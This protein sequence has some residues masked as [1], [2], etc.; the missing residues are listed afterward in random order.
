MAAS[1][2]SQVQWRYRGEL[3]HVSSAIRRRRS[4]T[5]HCGQF[6]RC[7]GSVR[8]A[9][10]RQTHRKHRALARLARN[11]HIAAHHPR[12]L[13]GDGKAKPRA[14]EALSGRGIGMTAEQQAKLFQDFTQADSLTAR[15]YGGTGL[16]LAISRKLARMMGGDVTVK[17]ELGKG[18]VFTVRLPGG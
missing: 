4:F 18:S 3:D 10:A 12:E 14:A 15:R 5:T 2:L 16:G 1:R 9:A 11:R 13:P 7:L 8:H 6:R 17:S